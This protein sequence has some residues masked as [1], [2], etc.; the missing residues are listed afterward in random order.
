MK[1]QTITALL[2]LILTSCAIRPTVVIPQVGGAPIVLSLGA[3][4]GTRSASERSSITH[5]GTTIAYESLSHDETV[6]P[7][8]SIGAGVAKSMISAGKSVLNN[9][10]KNGVKDSTGIES[11]VTPVI[12]GAVVG[13]GMARIMS[14]KKEPAPVVIER[15][16]ESIT[17]K[18]T[19]P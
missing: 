3:S 16:A 19:R 5:Q 9:A 14:K 7:V 12:G 2:A 11:M 17:T 8:A 6:I 4:L 10:T 18:P 1:N 15:P 13:A